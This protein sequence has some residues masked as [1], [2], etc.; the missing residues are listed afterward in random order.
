MTNLRLAFILSAVAPLL[1]G[2]GGAVVEGTVVDPHGEPLPGVAV[3]VEGTR[4]SALTN[5]VGRYKVR[6]VPGEV[7]LGFSKNGY[8]P[9]RLTR[10][11]PRAQPIRE[12]T[13]VRLDPLPPAPGVY[14]MDDDYRFWPTSSLKLDELKR[15]SDQAVVYGTRNP[16]SAETT[17]RGPAIVIYRGYNMPL[18]GVKLTKLEKAEVEQ[19]SGLSGT[20]G[21]E[22][23]VA[24]ADL[25]IAVNPI[26][27]EEQQLLQIQLQDIL[28]LGA[29][30]VHW[31]ALYGD[32]LS[33]QQ[34]IFCFRIVDQLT[35]VEPEGEE[36]G[37]GAASKSAPRAEEPTAPSEDDEG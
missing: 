14:L 6:Y 19:Q 1:S 27:Q 22:A 33:E 9:N 16:I 36:Q 28:E 30:A 7:V 37:D 12:P 10:Q 11:W 4:Y 23:W 35:P 24:G 34:R 5:G 2:C 29:Y 31:G 13:A 20:E 15:K 8:T 25:P 26:D 32:T 3:R 21:V 18:Y 17:F